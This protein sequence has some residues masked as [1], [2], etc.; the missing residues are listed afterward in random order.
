MN[1]ESI[2]TESINPTLQNLKEKL[3]LDEAKRLVKKGKR[4]MKMHP[5]T[6]AVTSLL[7]GLVV[8]FLARAVMER[9]RSNGAD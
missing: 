4:Y 7:V 8:G 6:V 2:P 9:R 5:T 3:H 1:K